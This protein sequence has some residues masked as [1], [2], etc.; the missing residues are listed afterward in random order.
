VLRERY[1]KV[2]ILSIRIPRLDVWNMIVVESIPVNGNSNSQ[3][4]VS[5]A[6]GGHLLEYRGI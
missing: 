4:S 3:P 1:A 6:L 5:G 2:G